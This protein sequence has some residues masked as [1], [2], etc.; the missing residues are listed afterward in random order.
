[1]EP[2]KKSV[3]V[4]LLLAV[5][6][7]PVFGEA[8]KASVVKNIDALVDSCVVLPCSFSHPGGLL[9]SSRLRGLWLR[10]SKKDSFIYSEDETMVMD[11]FKGRTKMLGVLGESNCTLEINAVKDHDNGP[12]CFRIELV[13]QPN[14]PPTPEKFSFVE[15]C[16]ELKMLIETPKP[17][18][19]HSNTAV[20]GTSYTVICSVRHT[21]P[22]RVPVFTWN[23]GS[24]D[25]IVEIQKDIHSGIWETQSILTFIPNENDDHTDII[26]TATFSGGKSSKSSIKFN[27]KRK[28]SYYHIIIPVAVAIGTAVTFGVICVFMLK[29][30]KNRIAEL[31]SREGSMFN[32][33]SR[34]SR[35]FHSSGQ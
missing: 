28:E 31:Q 16:A 20:S 19:H 9:P 26:C 7:S 3:I 15:D 22:S 29:K 27:V 6:Y 17:E 24:K 32:R 8:W 30:Y 18:L 35:R 33:L 11:A 1:M 34:M 25:D 23:R 13:K 5:I 2:D 10:G 12:L 4:F 21:C 14:S